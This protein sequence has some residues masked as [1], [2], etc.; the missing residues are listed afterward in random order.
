MLV[1][2][3]RPKAIDIPLERLQF[4]PD[5]LGFNRPCDCLVCQAR[6]HLAQVHGVPESAIKIHAVTPLQEGPPLLA[7]EYSPPQIVPFD[8]NRDGSPRVP[9][10]ATPGSARSP[11][12]ANEQGSVLALPRRALSLV[13]RGLVGLGQAFG[14]FIRNEPPQRVVGGE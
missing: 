1:V 10:D 12:A 5:P 7:A 2:H 4:A 11:G 8:K 6:R 9:R 3:D 14:R 13:G